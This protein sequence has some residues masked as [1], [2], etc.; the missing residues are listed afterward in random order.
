M[1]TRQD[2]QDWILSALRSMDGKGTIVEV[3][4]YI[5]D[6]Y[7]QELRNSGKL[8][9]TWQYD[10]RWAT[11]M[12]RKKGLLKPAAESGDGIWELV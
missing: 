3:C 6:N 9:Y 2:I 1:A 12:L 11:L 7:N 5:W 10:S 8:F 4:E